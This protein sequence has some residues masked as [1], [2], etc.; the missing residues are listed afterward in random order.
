MLLSIT[1]EIPTMMIHTK[2][3]LETIHNNQIAAS[4]YKSILVRLTNP[5]QTTV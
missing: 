4:R 5:N 1:L 3:V 2:R